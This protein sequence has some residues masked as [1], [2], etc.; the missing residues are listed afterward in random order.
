MTCYSN[1]VKFIYKKNLRG[2]AWVCY[3]VWHKILAQS[4]FTETGS[5]MPAYKITGKF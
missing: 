3:V 5:V 4:C 2:K 1:N